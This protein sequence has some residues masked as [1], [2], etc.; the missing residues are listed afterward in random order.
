M[1]TRPGQGAVA[2]GPQV[3]METEVYQRLLRHAGRMQADT[4][5]H[6]TLQDALRDLLDRAEKNGARR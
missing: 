2:R 5:R 4:G 3:R 6:V 1:N